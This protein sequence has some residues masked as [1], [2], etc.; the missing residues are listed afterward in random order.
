MREETMK[1]VPE[2]LDLP[3]TVDLATVNAAEIA[4]IRLAAQRRIDAREAFYFSRLL[5][6]RRRAIGDRTLEEQMTRLEEAR[7]ARGKKP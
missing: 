4:V 7:K 5:E 3:D 2:D 6:H 1:R